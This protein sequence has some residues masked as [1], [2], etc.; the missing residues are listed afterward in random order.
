MICFTREAKTLCVSFHQTQEAWNYVHRE[1]LI[2]FPDI[3]VHAETDANLSCIAFKGLLICQFGETLSYDS[4]DFVRMNCVNWGISTLYLYI[5][6]SHSRLSGK[7]LIHSP[8]EREERNQHDGSSLERV[9]GKQ[10][11]IPRPLGRKRRQFLL[12]PGLAL[13]Y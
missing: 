8:T 11:E 13:G 3:S 5:Y 2:L 4:L 10:G 7:R 12:S 9:P 6:E 1:S